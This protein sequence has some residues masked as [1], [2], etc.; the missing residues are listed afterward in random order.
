MIISNNLNWYDHSGYTKMTAPYSNVNVTNESKSKRSTV[1]EKLS[2]N[3]SA[4]ENELRSTKNDE[5]ECANGTQE[6]AKNE[7]ACNV[8][9]YFN[10]SNVWEC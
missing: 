1:N 4:K 7:V 10:V 2:H 9:K 3:C 5:S 6:D 8:K